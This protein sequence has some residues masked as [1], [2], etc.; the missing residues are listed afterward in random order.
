MEE[1]L[2][3]SIVVDILEE[4]LLETFGMAHLSKNLTVPADDTLDCVI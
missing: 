4:I 3:A 1:R 2:L